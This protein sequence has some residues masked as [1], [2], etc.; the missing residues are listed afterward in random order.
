M[1]AGERVALA[2]SFDALPSH[3]PFAGVTRRTLT[4][5]RMTIASYSF[6]PGATFPL[7]S[8]T[9]EQWTLVE[10]G[11]VEMTIGGRAALMRPGEWS[12]VDPGVEHGITAGDDGARVL[13]VIAPPR[14]FA[15]DYDL[16]AAPASD[17]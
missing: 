10:L 6:E 11:S 5:S 4:A 8:H 17:R 12:V 14:A 15:D 3:Q 16:A 1:T 9:Q 2:R 13:A 7:H